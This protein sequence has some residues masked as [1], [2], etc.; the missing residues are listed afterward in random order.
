MTLYAQH[1]SAKRTP[2]TEPIPGR[3]DM[4]PNSAG[5]FA[6]AADDWTRLD[7]FLVLGNEG[8]T[9][10]ASERKLTAENAVCV[11][12]CLD[13]D[14]VRTVERIT[15][16]SVSARAPKNDPAVFA[17]ALAFAHK[18]EAG[19]RAAA[20]ALPKVCR[21]AT[22]LFQ[23]AAS[24]Q[25]MRGWG[26]ALRNA[27]AEWYLSRGTRDLC[28]Q[29]VK[30]QQRGGWTHRDLLRLSHPKAGGTRQGVL[31][32]AVK[33]WESVGEEP[34][35]DADLLP[36]WAAE[37]AKRA[38]TADEV[39]RLIRDYDLVRECVPTQWLNEAAVWDAL[40]EKMP[41]TA[42]VR[43]LATMTRAGLLA[44]LSAA[45]R[46]VCDRL[47]DGERLKK[48][49]IHPVAV[50]AALLTYKQGRGERG[51]NVWTPVSQVVDALDGA[52]YAAFGNVEPTGKRWL[53][54]LDVSGSMDS[55]TVAGVPGL[56][57]R[58]GAAALSLVTAATERDH[59]F[60][61]FSHQL[62]PLA[63]SPRQ[64]LDDVA[65]TMRRT[66]MGRTDCSLPMVYAA[67]QGIPVDVFCVVTDNETYAG[68]VHPCQALRQY[69]QRTGI[70]A[71]LI[72]VGM[73]ATEISI[74]DPADAGSLDVIGFDSAAPQVMADFAR[75]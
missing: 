7:R 70:P 23:F 10:Y 56:T 11:A 36:A 34:H 60:V 42:M 3:T 61:G 16:I 21:T 4:T 68:P 66:P 5:G 6:F 12:R 19:K 14:C 52:F 50:L 37:R 47:A 44:P 28:Y 53:F 39:V 57:P 27:V 33:G 20:A 67:Q 32:Y 54:G 13:L 1:V 38:T 72:V 40:L 46:T 17:L 69:R 25:E 9:Y 62:V 24:V 30:Y 51:K 29:I 15:E 58:V 45:L 41:L 31:H 26:R 64:R 35:P 59:H 63:I 22:H 55:G 2:Q 8:G 73:T 18:N 49:R 48:A 75:A 43:N 71:K 65:E 74:A